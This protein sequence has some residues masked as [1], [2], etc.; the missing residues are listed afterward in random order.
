MYKEKKYET[1]C[2]LHESFSCILKIYL[3]IVKLDLQCKSPY[4]H[5]LWYFYLISPSPTFIVQYI[6]FTYCHDRF[7]DQALTHKHNKYDPLN[8][9][10]QDRGWQTN[11][12][13]TITAGVRGAIHEHFIQKLAHLK[14]PKT[15]IKIFMKNI[16]QNAIKYLTYL[17]LNK[18]K[19]DNK[20]APVPPPK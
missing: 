9:V 20:Q 15:T 8:N 6:E 2:I 19:L 14:I 10:I 16:H 12:L 11:P 7:P 18:R 5:G 1:T 17:I 13:I 4:F 3:M